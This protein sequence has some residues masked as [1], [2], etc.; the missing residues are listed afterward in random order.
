[1]KYRELQQSLKNK[2]V[3]TPHDIRFFEPNIATTQLRRWERI[4]YIQRLVRGYYVFADLASALDSYG[5]FAVAKN[6]YSPSYI[7]LESALRY[8]NLISEG[9]FRTTSISTRKTAVYKTPL[10]EFLFK[11]IKPT[12]MVGYTSVAYGSMS[13]FIA[14]KEKALVDYLYFHPELK[15]EGDMHELRIN[16]EEL[17]AHFD[18]PLFWKYITISENGALERRARLLLNYLRSPTYVHY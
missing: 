10:G 5:L 13:F 12:M 16:S 9:V 1:M 7:S 8:Y 3:F 4:G 11:S 2:L 14:T 17:F 15:T 18:E 6:L